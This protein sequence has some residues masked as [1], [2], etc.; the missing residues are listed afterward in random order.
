MGVLTCVQKVRNNQGVIISYIMQDTE[1]GATQPIE[2]ANLKYAI[3]NNKVAVNNLKLTSDG[4]LIDSTNGVGSSDIIGRRYIEGEK[5]FINSTVQ[6]LN[7]LGVKATY[8][9]VIHNVKN[10]DSSS[11]K[12]A[13]AVIEISDG[14]VVGHNAKKGLISSTNPSILAKGAYYSIGIGTELTLKSTHA[15]G[16]NA[17]IDY[18]LYVG[19]V[20]T[21]VE[22]ADGAYLATGGS[23][24]Q[25]LSKY[26]NNEVRTYVATTYKVIYDKTQSVNGID[27]ASL[28]SYIEKT[29]MYLAQ[30]I[31]EA[32]SL[33]EDELSTVYKLGN[34][35]SGAA[36]KLHGTRLTNELT[37]KAQNSGY[38][39][40]IADMYQQKIDQAS[41]MTEVAADRLGV[42]TSQR[43]AESFNEKAKKSG[44]IFGAFK[45]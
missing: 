26:L 36:A 14:R 31:I 30:K 8:Q 13:C 28:N 21:N 23:T 41:P 43:K 45:R 5:L 1:T 37:E 10:N 18:Q 4:R 15:D 39:T 29:G 27:Y 24:M 20:K 22:Y 35:V 6:A 38:N 11:N 16:N 12:I 7:D 17:T 2:A 3:F 40:D 34:K 42:K 44:G 32:L 33:K 19:G 25:S 9:N